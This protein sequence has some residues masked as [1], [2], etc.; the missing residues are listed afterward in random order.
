MKLVIGGV[1]GAVVGVTI[2]PRIPQRQ[3]KLVLSLWLLF[4]GFDFFLKAAKF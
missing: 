2:S 4:I 3:L 1:L